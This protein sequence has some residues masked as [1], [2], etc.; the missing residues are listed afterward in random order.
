[1]SAVWEVFKVNKDDETKA[2]CGLC[3]GIKRFSRGTEKRNRGTTNL[4]RHLESAHPTKWKELNDNE[5]KRK[6]ADRKSLNYC[7]LGWTSG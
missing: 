7:R 6:A 5:A 1:M 2:I 4:R 3:L